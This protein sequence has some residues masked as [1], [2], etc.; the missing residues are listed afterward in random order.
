[1]LDVNHIFALFTLIIAL[2]V[3]VGDVQMRIRQRISQVEETIW[4]E[5]QRG[6]PDKKHISDLEQDILANE[7]DGG[8][9]IVADIFLVILG[10]LLLLR[11]LIWF[12][13]GMQ[14]CEPAHLHTCNLCVLDTLIVLL[15]ALAILY[16]ILLHVRQWEKYFK[17]RG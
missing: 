6:T 14:Q 7:T 12:F 9:L 15:F 13:A 4:Q 16:L 11:L 3:Y 5:E 10:L 8:W 1:M 17:K 2:A